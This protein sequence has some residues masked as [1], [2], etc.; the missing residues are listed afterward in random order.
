MKTMTCRELGG[1]CDDKMSAN[2]SD[3]MMKKGM[4]HLE[5]AHPEMAKDIKAMP[6]GDPKM[7]AWGEKFKKDWDAA[8]ESDG[9]K[10]DECTHEH[11]EKD[12]SCKC[13]CQKE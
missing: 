3:E 12:G 9:K 10:C 13:G 11:A 2:T 1:M 5:A 4:M 6:E 8:S 7:I